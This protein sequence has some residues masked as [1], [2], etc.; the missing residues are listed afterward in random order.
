MLQGELYEKSAEELRSRIED[1]EEENF[2]LSEEISEWMRT[3]DEL[4]GRYEEQN[5]T[6]IEKNVVVARDTNALI[7][8][9]HFLQNLADGG[10]DS[11]EEEKIDQMCGRIKKYLAG[12]DW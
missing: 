10:F 11:I 5:L 1:L 7:D 9:L 4:Y 6:L 3:Y 12:E 2:S 8:I